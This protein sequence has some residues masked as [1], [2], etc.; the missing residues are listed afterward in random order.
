M[1]E[2]ITNKTATEMWQNLIH[3]ASEL[4]HQS[5]DE[6]LES[7]LVFMLMRH[8]Q[9]TG[10]AHR[11]LAPDY[12]T[13]MQTQGQSG[14]QQLQS[15]GDQCL[16]FSGFYPMRSRRRL[17]KARY[18]V[19]LGRSAYMQMADR[20]RQA[21]VQLYENLSRHFVEM[22][23]V[24]Q[25]LRYSAHAEKMDSLMLIENWQD[26]NSQYARQL[27]QERYAQADIHQQKKIK[28]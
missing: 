22:M 10:L 5:L 28:H 27:L 7:Y 21:Y 16:L 26:S 2:I 13:G 14:I 15:V 20:V 19:D 11:V 18:Y 6:E 23:D 17:V 4:C 12:L 25:A 3:G 8:L 9:D 1:S 24:L